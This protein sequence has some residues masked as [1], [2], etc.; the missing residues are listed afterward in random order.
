MHRS[1]R[2]APKKANKRHPRQIIWNVHLTPMPS[3]AVDAQAYSKLHLD[4]PFMFARNVSSEE[5]GKVDAKTTLMQKTVHSKAANPPRTEKLP[6]KRF[7]FLITLCKNPYKSESWKTVDGQS[8]RK[9]MYVP[10]HRFDFR[11]CYTPCPEIIGKSPRPVSRVIS[12]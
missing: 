7:H 12:H 11:H 5:N 3:C 4:W 1:S 9:L 6:G 10:F 2:R 8:E